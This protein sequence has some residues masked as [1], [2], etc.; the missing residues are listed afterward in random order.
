MINQSEPRQ[1]SE[2]EIK[3]V[4]NITQQ[5]Q[6]IFPSMAN[7]SSTFALSEYKKQLTKA[8]TEI[9]KPITPDQIK[10]TLAYLRVNGGKFQPSVPEFI[11]LCQRKNKS[12]A[13]EHA[14]FDTK[15]LPKYSQ[16]DIK[17]FAQKEMED[18]RKRR[19]KAPLEEHEVFNK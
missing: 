12:N 9:K 11:K 18:I 8:F 7:T 1:I 10:Q 15:Q 19:F 17:S 6:G 16:S 3:Y 4:N 5:L 13:P 2:I 14:W